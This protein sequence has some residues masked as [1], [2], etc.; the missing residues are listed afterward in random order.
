MYFGATVGRY[1]ELGGGGGFIQK[2]LRKMSQIC[3]GERLGVKDWPDR[4]G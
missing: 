4:L 2:R 3:W 1:I